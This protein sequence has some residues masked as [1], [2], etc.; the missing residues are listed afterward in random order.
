M[1]DCVGLHAIT[2]LVA[3]NFDISARNSVAWRWPEVSF[4]KRLDS[5]H[6]VPPK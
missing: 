6:I 1:R 5:S 4:D 3:A 2:R